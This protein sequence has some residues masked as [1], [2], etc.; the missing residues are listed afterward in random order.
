MLRKSF[1]KW[2]DIRPIRFTKPSQ[3][4]CVGFFY[5]EAMRACSREPDNEKDATSPS[6]VKTLG[7]CFEV[8]F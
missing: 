7:K 6:E 2:F 8:V 3:R 1:M 5:W 4:S